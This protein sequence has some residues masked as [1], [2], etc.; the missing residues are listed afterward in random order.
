MSGNVELVSDVY[1]AEALFGH[2][3][4]GGDAPRDDPEHRRVGL[5]AITPV[6][7]W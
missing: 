5:L 4:G 3:D 6:V 7:G 1:G 2:D